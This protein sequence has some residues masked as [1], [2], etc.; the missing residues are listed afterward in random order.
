M[1]LDPRPHSAGCPLLV[2]DL[3]TTAIVPTKQ[4]SLAKQEVLA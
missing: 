2:I 3:A 4:R 1:A